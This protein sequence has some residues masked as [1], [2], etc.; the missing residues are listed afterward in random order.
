MTATAESIPNIEERTDQLI[1]FLAEQRD[2]YRQLK[3]LSE[4]Q[5]RLI[6]DQD[7]EA[8][9]KVLAERQRLVD[10]L[11]ELNTS[12]APFRREWASTYTQMKP[13]HRQRVQQVLDDISKS[14]EE[15]GR[16]EQGVPRAE[17][18]RPGR[19]PAPPRR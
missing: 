15:S 19:E 13:E 8:L 18:P 7:P 12:L 17:P 11:A 6:T 1:A 10:R 2:C 3:Q 14:L 4:G 16:E 5:R 9:L